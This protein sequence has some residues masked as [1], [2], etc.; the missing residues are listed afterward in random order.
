MDV[1]LHEQITLYDAG[2]ILTIPA[3]NEKSFEQIFGR[4]C[5]RRKAQH[6]PKP[7]TGTT[8]C[9]KYGRYLAS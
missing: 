9:S 2:Y 8:I 3:N 1:D 6:E 7:R 5:S 4:H